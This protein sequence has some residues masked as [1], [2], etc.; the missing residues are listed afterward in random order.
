MNFIEDLKWR[1]ALNQVTDEE[2]L[3]QAMN[4]GQI[5]AYVGTDPTADSLH[6]GHLI[7]FMVLKR[8]QNAGGKA[9]IIVGGATGSIG[10]PRPTT[11]RKLL[12][13][14]QL[15]ENEKGIAAQVTKLFGQNG[16]KIVNNADWLNTMSLPT[17]LRDYGK[18]FFH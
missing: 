2:G 6:L 9:V 8:F 17:F 14:E 7:P 3:L 12:S 1:G 15:K 4:E 16:T 18:L 13:E 5:G 10:D 11:E